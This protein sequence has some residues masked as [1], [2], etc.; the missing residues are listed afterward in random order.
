MDKQEWLAKR[1]GGI[2]GSDAAVVLGLSKWKSPLELYLEKRGE[3][4]EQGDSEPMYWGR[5]LEPAIRQR[6]ADE[7][8]RVVV[9]PREIMWHP[10]IPW[11]L[12]NPDGI[13]DGNRV[14]EIKTARVANGWGT[15]GTD[16]IPEYYLPQVQ[17]NMI[18]TGLSV[19][20][21][22]VLI[23]GSDYRVYEVEADR[24]LQ[25]MI[26]E[27]ERLFWERVQS[28]NPPDPVSFSDM[29]LRFGGA[30]TEASVQA[31]AEV[32]DAINRLR[33]IKG[34]GNEL[35]QEEKELKA[36]VMGHMGEADTMLDGEKIIATWK[37]DKPGERFSQTI[38]KEK[39]PDIYR[40]CQEPKKP[41]R[42]F[43]VK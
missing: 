28:G 29:Q 39:H 41:T 18:V 20:D 23:G 5:A 31:T 33:E 21:V 6:Y 25:E 14:V 42:R 3:G 10:E 35:E 24:E 30:S 9:V 43:L 12:A 16:E 37:M 36:L 2:G 11:M 34:I 19:A 8:G 27:F 15:P 38:L 40:F 13:A 4:P 32:L 22:P 26:I 1:L 17:H 7:T